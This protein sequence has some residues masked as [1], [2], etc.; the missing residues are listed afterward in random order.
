MPVHGV[1]AVQ[2]G[3]L[4]P[5]VRGVPL[6]PVVEIGP[7]L[8]AVAL[9]GVG[10]AAAQ[11]GADEVGFDVRQILDVL[12]I[13]LGHLP[14]FFRQRHSRQQRFH[15]GVKRRQRPGLRRGGNSR[16]K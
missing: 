6:Q 1:D 9:L 15:L 11:N 3:N 10:G 7:R 5:R 12:L 16:A 2:D 13:G 8:Q 4:E 14:D